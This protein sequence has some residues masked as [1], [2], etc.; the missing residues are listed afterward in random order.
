MRLIQS[1]N[2]CIVKTRRHSLW[3]FTV[4]SRRLNASVYSSFLAHKS[5]DQR[6]RPSWMML[7]AICA[8]LLLTSC[9]QETQKV[10]IYPAPEGIEFSQAFVVE[11]DSK[12]VPVYKTKIPPSEAVPRLNHSRSEF[13]FASFVSFDMSEK[14][15]VKVTYPKAINSVEILPTSFGIESIIDGNTVVCKLDA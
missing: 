14:V 4:H 6:G 8:I 11:V 5:D 2:T 15:E 9:M 1:L 12:A 10:R 3:P 7:V 13:G